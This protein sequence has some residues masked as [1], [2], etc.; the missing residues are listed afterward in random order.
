MLANFVSHPHLLSSSNHPSV[1]YQKTRS[2]PFPPNR[3]FESKLVFRLK[4]NPIPERKTDPSSID[5]PEAARLSSSTATAVRM[6]RRNFICRRICV[7]FHVS[8]AI[9]PDRRRLIFREGLRFL[10]YR[11]GIH[12][13]TTSGCCCVDNSSINN[14]KIEITIFIERGYTAVIIDDRVV[15]ILVWIIERFLPAIN[16]IFYVKWINSLDP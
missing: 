7:E 14:A 6:E 1:L 4:L 3:H 12:R 8:P 9:W 5:R 10:L 11:G 2:F 16:M 15:S 13:Y